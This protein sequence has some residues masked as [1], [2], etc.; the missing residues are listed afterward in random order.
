[1][2][3]LILGASSNVGRALARVFAAGNSLT[4]MGRNIERLTQT[5]NGCL[6]Q[7]A[8]EITIV[9][10][11]LSFDMDAMFIAFGSREIDLVIDA[12]SASSRR[13][14]SDLTAID[15]RNIVGTD[16]FA[17]TD[18]VRRILDAQRRPPS[19]ILISTV[20]TLVKSPGQTVYPGLKGIYEKF[21][22]KLREEVP[23]FQLL[24]VY[25]GTVIDREKGS[26]R[27]TKLARAVRTA[28]EG[29]RRKILFGVSGFF[30]VSLFYLQPLIFNL[31]TLV[32]RKLRKSGKIP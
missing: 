24:V 16:V 2:H 21:L 17:K 29:K 25:V 28:F 6:E 10:G 11:D 8:A 26:V 9:D 3:I 31:V 15:I 1:M 23:D 7:G 27:A 22:Q 5:G 19:F 4:L 14:D 13:R 18:L 30:L 32:Q 12:A 20:L